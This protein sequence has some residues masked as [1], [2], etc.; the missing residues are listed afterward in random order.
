MNIISIDNPNNTDANGDCCN[1][2]EEISACST[3]CDVSVN[4]CIQPSGLASSVDCDNAIFSIVTSS[5]GAY[6]VPSQPWP[7]GDIIVYTL[8]V[9]YSFK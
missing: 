5:G 6:H 1:E 4:F 2:T 9:V 3:A 7:V 8:H